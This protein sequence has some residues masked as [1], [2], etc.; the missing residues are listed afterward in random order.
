MP[1]DPP[2]QTRRVVR[3]V[4]SKASVTWSYSR[5]WL[6]VASN[7]KEQVDK[8][9]TFPGKRLGSQYLSTPVVLL[10]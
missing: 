7:L 10:P 5:Q 4:V 2:G 1:Y 8:G 3:P 9:L 6:H